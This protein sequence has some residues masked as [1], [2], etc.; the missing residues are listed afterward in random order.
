MT[1]RVNGQ[2]FA[3]QTREDHVFT[4]RV[5]LTGDIRVEAVAGKCRDSAA[6]RKVEKPNA[7]YVLKKS[8]NRQKSNWV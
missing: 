5:P 6:F 3:E 2:F 4:F 1:L 7:D 8:Q